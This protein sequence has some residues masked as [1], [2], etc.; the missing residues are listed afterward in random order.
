MIHF[1]AA[2]RNHFYRFFR[3]MC[4]FSLQIHS[5]KYYLLIWRF[6]SCTT[7]FSLYRFLCFKNITLRFLSITAFYAVLPVPFHLQHLPTQPLAGRRFFTRFSWYSRILLYLLYNPPCRQMF[8]T[9]VSSMTQKGRHSRISRTMPVFVVTDSQS[10]PLSKRS[11][12]IITAGTVTAVLLDDLHCL[13]MQWMHLVRCQRLL[14]VIYP[15]QHDFS[16]T[17]V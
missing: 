7:V 12:F 15:M 6:L 4:G 14:A 8:F 17:G 2:K 1:S 11:C 13:Q 3:C 9:L 5:F 16:R 10:L